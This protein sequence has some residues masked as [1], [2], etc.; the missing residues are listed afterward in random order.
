M[1]NHLSTPPWHL[2]CL[3]LR[4]KSLQEVKAVEVSAPFVPSGRAGY[5][6]SM[7]TELWVGDAESNDG[8]GWPSV[9]PCILNVC[10]RI[11]GTCCAYQT[12]RSWLA[13]Q[14]IRTGKHRTAREPV[15]CMS[16]TNSAYHCSL[17]GKNVFV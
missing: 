11:S 8:D 3:R 14:R 13:E 9:C 4:F 15:S 12:F 10:H 16:S 7:L 5:K 2:G 6:M 17:K 1:I